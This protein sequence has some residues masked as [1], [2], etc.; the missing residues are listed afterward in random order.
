MGERSSR[1]RRPTAIVAGMIAT[2]PVGGVV[3]D[4]GQ[5]ALG[6]EQLGYDVYYLEDTT[7]LTY[8]P[9]ARTVADDPQYAVA[10]LEASLRRLSAPL[11]QRW[12]FRSAMGRTYGIDA[13]AFREIIAGA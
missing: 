9:Q 1:A 6:L 7:C 13:A 5:Y 12:H 4:Y 8:D 3:W 2:F 10:Y 11:G